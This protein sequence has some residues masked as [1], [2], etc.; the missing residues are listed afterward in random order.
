MQIRKVSI[1]MAIK[2]TIEYNSDSEYIAGFLQS[3]INESE[4]DGSVSKC[5]R[6]IV[7]TLDDSDPE[8]LER[9]SKNTQKF[10]PYSVYIGEID[11]KQEDIEVNSSSFESKNYN[12]ALCPKCLLK[13]RDPASDHYLDDSLICDHYS[14]SGNK[15]FKDLHNYSAHY[16]KGDTL[17]VVDTSKLDKL[18]YLTQN[19][20]DALLSIEKPTIKVTIKDEDLKSSTKENF[21]YIK[22]PNTMKSTLSAL[23]AKESGLEYLFFKEFEMFKVSITKDQLLIIKDTLGLCNKLSNLS[24]DNVLNRFLNIAEEAGVRRA[25]G[26][27]LS[28]ENSISFLVTDKDETKRAL[29]FGKFELTK[30]LDEF[31]EK[32][33]K[34]LNN[35]NEKYPKLLNELKQNTQYDLFETL[36]TILELDDRGYTALSNK[37]LEFHGNGGLRIDTFFKEDG[38]DYGSFIG[39][40]ISFKLADSDAHY[41]AYSIFEALADMAI[42]ALNQLKDKYKI[43]NFIMM[44]SML[45]NSVLHSRIISKF[46]QAY[47]YFPKALSVDD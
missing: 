10:L 27:N 30:I 42:S 33:P 4:I 3:I 37:S 17:L 26:V 32:K 5:E 6:E 2:Q 13:L 14:N 36:C 9:F 28:A 39:S 47:P 1:K 24:E 20:V 46:S 29:N 7:L 25:L 23:N 22:S 45:E 8:A 34:L 18:F 11:T 19:E 12:I 16:T 41:L 35:L 15:D 44:G 43:S 38:F 31:R 21:I 40:I